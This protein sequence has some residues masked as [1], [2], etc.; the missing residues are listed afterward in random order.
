[1]SD[2]ASGKWSSIKRMPTY[3]ELI[4]LFNRTSTSN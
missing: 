1:L 2:P 3:P 4:A